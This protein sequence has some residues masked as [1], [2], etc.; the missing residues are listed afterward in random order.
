MKIKRNL[1]TQE[2]RDFWDFVKRTAE[3]VDNWPEYKRHTLCHK[4]DCAFHPGEN[5]RPN[6]GIERAVK[7]ARKLK[8][9]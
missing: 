7:R 9:D 6:N 4:G 2:N 8:N 1:K 3:E 5:C